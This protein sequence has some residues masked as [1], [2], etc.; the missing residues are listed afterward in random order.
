LAIADHI[1]SNDASFNNGNG[2]NDGII[3]ARHLANGSV[4]GSAIS[5]Y[6]TTRQ[7]DTTNTTETAARIL[8]GWGVIA[9]NTGSTFISETVT[10]GTPFTNPPIILT[11]FAGDHS[12]SQIYGSNGNL[13]EA[14]VQTKPVLPTASGFTVYLH[15]PSGGNFSAGFGFYTW[16]AIGA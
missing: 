15:K 9:Y 8:T 13:V 10:F 4:T 6:L 11:S 12:T 2:F 14:L 16:I 3:I 7:N 1:G 5:S